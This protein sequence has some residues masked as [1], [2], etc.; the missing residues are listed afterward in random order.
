M[1]Q[2]VAGDFSLAPRLSHVFADYDEV[3]VEVEPQHNGHDCGLYMLK[4]IEKLAKHQPR[5]GISKR[6]IGDLRWSEHTSLAFRAR[7]IDE[8]RVQ[9]RTAI[10]HAS[11]SQAMQKLFNGQGLPTRKKRKEGQ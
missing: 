4:Y 6:R 5:L 3:H 9:M 8:A 1:P 2:H 11:K 10:R 7:D